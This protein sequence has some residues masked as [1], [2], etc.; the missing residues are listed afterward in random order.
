MKDHP[1]WEASYRGDEP[2]PW[3]IGKPQPAFARLAAAGA[4][5]GT[6]LDAGCGTGEHALLAASLGLPALGVDVAGT[7]IRMAREKARARGLK[8][9]F[10]VADALHLERLGKTFDTVLDCGLFHSFENEERPAYV[11]NLAAVTR[12]GGRCYVLC[13]SDQEPNV[14]PHPV[15]ED[16][17]RAAFNHGSG[18]E[19]TALKAERI[20]TLIHG[21][22]VSAWMVMLKRT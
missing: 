7:A 6:V 9:E 2:A 1:P 11:A 14:G 22:D 8:A 12:R 21:D 15:R 5:T 4:F 13:F 19:I 17:L 3:D 16:E 10:A 18:W 20:E